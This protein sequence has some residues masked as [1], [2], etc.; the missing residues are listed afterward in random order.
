MRT[1]SSTGTSPVRFCLPPW[2]IQ[3]QRSPGSCASREALSPRTIRERERSWES[4]A[5]RAFGTHSIRSSRLTASVLIECVLR[6]CSGRAGHVSASGCTRR[7]RAADV[8]GGE[9]R[10]QS[11][12]ITCPS[13]LSPGEAPLS[14][15]HG[16][17]PS[18]RRTAYG[19][20]GCR[21]RL[22]HSDAATSRKVPSIRYAPR[23]PMRRA[24]PKRDLLRG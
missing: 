12:S 6:R 14:S 24:R 21:D 13:S 4:R 20:G 7:N 15:R 10:R 8:R 23:L 1:P 9:V 18:Q 3:Y 19:V 5:A 11:N 22:R 16:I 17:I 2:D